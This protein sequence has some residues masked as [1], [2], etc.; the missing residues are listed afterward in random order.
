MKNLIFIEGVS[1]AGKSTMT[2]KLCEKLQDNGYSVN[3]Y[4]E[5]DIKS[6]VDSFGQ[7]YLSKTEYENIQLKYPEFTDDLSKNCISGYEYN[8]VRYRDNKQRYYSTKLYEYLKECE[9][10]Y[11]P[12][13]PL[14]FIRYTKVFVDMWRRFT[15]SEQATQDF[16]IC[17][18]SF[19]HHQINDLIRNYNASED[20]IF[21]HLTELLRIVQ[22]LNPII[23]YLS[24][25][26]V[27]ERLKKARDSRGQNEPTK[28]AIN[29]WEKRKDIDLRILNRLPVESHIIDISDDMRDS[30]FDKRF[31]DTP[32]TVTV[33]VFHGS[34][35]KGNTYHATKIFMDELS[36]HENVHFTEFFLPK[37][38]PVFCTGC[39]L[40]LGGKRE[41]C[42][43]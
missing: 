39:T 16:I 21:K 22:P 25:Q 36:K 37:D 12:A 20:D 24:S 11:N 28:D 14:P 23:F 27:G 13:K 41:K 7:A 17:D 3:C 19:L 42:R 31:G 26:N 10:C 38:L 8:L 29:F 43:Q 1:G 2:P 35:R 33:T 30:A 34:P 32:K 4:L 9:F 40:C 18:G 6:P 5:G 15:E